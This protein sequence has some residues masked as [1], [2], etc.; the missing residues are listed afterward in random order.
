M[1]SNA[2]DVATVRAAVL[3]DAAPIAAIY[4]HY[5]TTTIVTFEE[6]PFA[7]AEMGRRIGDVQSASLPWL[8]AHVDGRV[9]GYASATRWKPRTGYRFSTEVAVYV[10]PGHAGQGIGSMLFGLLFP[11]L[12]DRGIHVV[13]GGIALPNQ[14][15]IALHEKF[16]FRKVAH[17]AEVGFKFNQWIDVGYWQRTL[18]PREQ[19]EDK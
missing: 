11:A 2:P 17:L 12:Q 9:V 6:E 4:N 10:A 5:V 13:M 3:S 14:P 8:V 19:S 16:G 7:D 15:S 1:P 18:Q